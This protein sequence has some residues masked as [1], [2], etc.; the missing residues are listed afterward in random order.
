MGQRTYEDNTSSTTPAFSFRGS[1]VVLGS[2]N[3][4]ACKTNYVLN[5]PNLTQNL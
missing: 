2:Q 4:P 3:V 1:Y 5:G